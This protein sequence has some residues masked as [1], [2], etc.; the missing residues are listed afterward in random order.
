MER[1]LKRKRKQENKIK[2]TVCNSNT[3][4]QKWIFSFWYGSTW[5]YYMLDHS[6]IDHIALYNLHRTPDLI[7]KDFSIPRVVIY[8]LQSSDRLSTSI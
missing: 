1:K 7:F 5:F 3:I 4:V 2:F 6:I 8:L